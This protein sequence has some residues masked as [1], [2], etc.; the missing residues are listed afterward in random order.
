ML[1][2]V[3]QIDVGV[4]QTGVN[5][6]N[7]SVSITRSSINDAEIDVEMPA[8]VSQ[9]NSPAPISQTASVSAPVSH[10]SSGIPIGG[11][12]RWRNTV[13][14]N[15]SSLDGPGINVEMPAS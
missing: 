7:D 5:R 9:S 4:R 14:I 11:L 6:L 10:I 13:P 2:P 12:N 15:S 8:Q 1:T 3:L